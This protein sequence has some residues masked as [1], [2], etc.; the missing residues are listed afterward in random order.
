[1]PWWS[2]PLV[3]LMAALLAA[4]VHMG[5]P[6]LR[7]WLPYVLLLPL[8]VALLI[9]A[10][11]VRVEVGPGADGERELRAGAAHLPV[12]AVG[13]V[14][15]VRGEAKREALGPQ[16][17]PE[18]FVLHRPWVG[19]AVRIEV[20]DPDDPTPYWVVSTRRPEDLIAALR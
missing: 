11:R 9:W 7:S 12:S 6:G 14:D 3:L 17:D 1:M 18:A 8:A 5:Y 16:L 4:E 13:R 20:L 19:P 2:W 15:V 10:G